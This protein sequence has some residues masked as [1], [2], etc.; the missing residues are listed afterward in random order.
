MENPK[1][2][3]LQLVQLSYTRNISLY[4]LT[5]ANKE[6]QDDKVRFNELSRTLSFKNK[7]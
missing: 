1:K 2:S 3:I 5:K 6:F 4:L 7:Q